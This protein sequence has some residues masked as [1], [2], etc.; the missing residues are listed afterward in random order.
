MNVHPVVVDALADGDIII[1]AVLLD[2][3]NQSMIP[4]IP[5]PISTVLLATR[6]TPLCH[7]MGSGPGKD[8]CVICQYPMQ[9]RR[10][11]WSALPCGHIFHSR[12][13]YGLC[14]APS[15]GATSALTCPLC[16]CAVHRDTLQLMGLR[17]SVGD[18]VRTMSRCDAVNQLLSGRVTTEVSLGNHLKQIRGLETA[19][20]FVRSACILHIERSIF[21]KI[22]LAKQLHHMQTAQKR[23]NDDLYEL[24]QVSIACHV[25]VLA[26]VRHAL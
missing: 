25:E 12:C 14:P 10:G 24:Y 1:D 15:T 16:R 22:Q 19:D 13:L 11:Q 5:R 17:V 26:A 4:Q 20:G 2:Y 8:L 3:S 23:S 18:L 9:K 7:P 6:N 21:H